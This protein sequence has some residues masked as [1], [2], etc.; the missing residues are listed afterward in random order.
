MPKLGNI[1]RTGVEAK[2][3][4]QEIAWSYCASS[5]VTIF[6]RPM[7]YIRVKTEKAVRIMGAII[8][9]HSSNAETYEF[10]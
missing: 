5:H 7:R 2:F 1:V 6:D 9:S 3:N 10:D 4:R 8:C